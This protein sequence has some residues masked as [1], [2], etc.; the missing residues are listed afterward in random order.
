MTTVT[1]RQGMISLVFCSFMWST[2]GLFI[3]LVNW[4]PMAICGIRGL[5]ASIIIYMALLRLGHK[6]P[7]MDKRSLCSAFFLGITCNLFVI[8]N[9]MTTAANAIM[10]QSTSPIFVILFSAV[11]KRNFPSKRDFT[12]SMLV[13]FGIMLF[14][15][16]QLTFTGLLGNLVALASGMLLAAAY[17]FTCE[18]KNVYESMSGVVLGHLFSFLL[19]IPFLFIYPID[20][21]SQSV[22][23]IL[24]LGIV[25]LGIPY[26]LF[27]IGTAVCSP[28]AVSLLSMLEPMFN[29]V[30]VALFLHEIPGPLALCGSV[31]VIITLSCW[32]ISGS[33]SER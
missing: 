21:S 33:K 11:F 26:V 13:L 18:A 6:M 14:F 1:K 22:T 25:Q 30:W 5:I 29:P 15:F 32:C 31:I 12:T 4:H 24:I 23:A 2:G 19:S 17:I 7:L 8:A 3:K 27:S 16:D 9:K 20:Y 10:L 28:L